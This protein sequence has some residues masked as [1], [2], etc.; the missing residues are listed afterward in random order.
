[1]KE[2]NQE[3]NI[4]Q[5]QSNKQKYSKLTKHVRTVTHFNKVYFDLKVPHGALA[6]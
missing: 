2:I 6:E 4:S 5:L 3:I 1:M